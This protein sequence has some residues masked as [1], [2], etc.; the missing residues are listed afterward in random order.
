MSSE[1]KPLEGA[2]VSATS[3]SRT[4]ELGLMS[5]GSSARTTKEGA[6]TLNGVAPG[7]YVLQARSLQVMTTSD[8]GGNTMVFTARLSTGGGGEG[9]SEFGSMPVSVG[10]EDLSNI[11]LVTSKGGTASGRV[12]FE[13]GAKPS[14][15]GSMRV[16]AASADMDT[17][18]TG[19]STGQVK[20]DGAFELKGVTGQRLFRVMNPPPGWTLKAVR[21]NGIE[22]TDTGVDF[23]AN[24]AISGLE[25]VLTSRTTSVT[26]GV[27]GSDGAPLKDYTVVIFSDDPDQWRLPMTRWVTGTRPDQ[28]GRFKVQNLPAGTYY[29]VAVDY[30]PQGEWGDPE[31]LERLRS[32]GK[33]FTLDDGGSQTLDLKLS[34]GY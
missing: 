30:V 25:V 2:M 29:A 34:D 28:E 5:M 4:G 33:R 13:D 19:G 14:S 8:S 23:K 15:P 17:P 1:G 26:G 20:P 11:V 3:G 31:L 10:G 12:I 32:S 9:D 18:F 21:L 16:S 24:E 7:D 27:T 6:F 22:V